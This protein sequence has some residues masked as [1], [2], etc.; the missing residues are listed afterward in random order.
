MR[1]PNWRRRAGRQRED[2]HKKGVI[3][4][5][6]AIDWDG[7]LRLHKV[8]MDW[9]LWLTDYNVSG[10]VSKGQVAL[11]R[12]EEQAAFGQIRLHWDA[13]RGASTTCHVQEG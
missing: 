11:D 5:K 7:W 10:P 4:R 9:S 8:R 12:L 13:C 6:G 2:S 3:R 1:N